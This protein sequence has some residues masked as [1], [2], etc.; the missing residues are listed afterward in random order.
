VTSSPEALSESVDEASPQKCPVHAHGDGDFV[1]LLSTDA[2]MSPMD[3]YES[4]R[5]SQGSVARVLVDGLPAWLVLGYQE[6]YEFL[7][8][9]Q[10]FTRDARQWNLEKEGKV[11]ADCVLRPMTDWEEGFVRTSVGQ[12]HSRI[13]DALVHGLD[14]VNRRGLRRQVGRY[15][16]ELIDAFCQD[17]RADLVPAFFY[18]LPMRVLGRIMGIPDEES[19][20]LVQATF[21]IYA[22]NE[23]ANAGNERLVNVLQT[24]VAEKRRNPG[25]DLTSRVIGHASGLSDAEVVTNL[26]MTLAIGQ[27]TTVSLL[28]NMMLMLLT[29]QRYR[30]RLSGNHMTLPDGIEQ[31][32]W[33]HPPLHALV[34]R[35]AVHDTELGGQRIKAGDLL[36]AGLAAGN[37][38]P[39]L[40]PDL[41]ADMFGNRSHL[42]FGGGPHGCP[43]S[44]ADTS[45]LI[46]EVAVDTLLNRLPHLRLEIEDDELPRH[47]GW[48][49]HHLATLPVTFTASPLSSAGARANAAPLPDIALPELPESAAAT[50]D[51]ST[52]PADQTGTPPVH[53]PQRGTRLKELWRKI[54]RRLR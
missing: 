32:L 4:L 36:I 47:R 5:R 6:N 42:A 16:D 23:N 37:R 11:P 9:S 26:R 44:A 24:V 19:A 13:R 21:D 33:D 34:A 18:P 8:D 20:G 41:S 25:S 22:G 43:A 53:K 27:E 35:W 50:V 49:N 12:E 40:R 45:R 54:V 17:G 52:G 51:T 30:A 2:V 14:Q 10:R 46:V 39:Q 15:A 38:D 31:M 3:T 28:A 1:D 7:L 29:D 48:V